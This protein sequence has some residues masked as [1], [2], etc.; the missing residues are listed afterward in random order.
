M[1]ILEVSW[2]N[3]NSYGNVL[4]TI[5][6]ESNGNLYLLTAKNG[7]G[8][9]TIS[10]V[11]TFGIYGK[12]EKKNKSSLPNRINKNLYVNIKLISNN[13]RIEITRGVAPV[14]F[15]VV[16]DGVVYDTSGNTNVQ[17]YLESEI[18]EIPFAVFKNIIVLS[19]NDFKSFLTMSPG[20]KRNIID[21]LFGI[22]VINK[23]KEFVKN[24]RKTLNSDLKTITDEVSFLETNIVNLSE[25]IKTIQETKKIDTAALLQGY[26][27][28]AI[29]LLAN[30]KTLTTDYDKI[31]S[32]YDK[33]VAKNQEQERLLREAEYQTKQ[34][35]S[36]LKL[37]ENA[38]CPLCKSD[39][40]TDEHE[41]YKQKLESD[42]AELLKHIDNYNQAI[43]K[44]SVVLEKISDKKMTLKRDL[45]TINESLSKTKYEIESLTKT[46]I[47]DDIVNLQSVIQDNEKKKATRIKD[48]EKTI[49]DDSFLSIVEDVLGDEGVK[50]LAMNTILPIFNHNITQM[51][52]QIH[53]PYTFK[54][55]DKFECI[56]NSLGEEISPLTLSTGERK[57]ADFIIIIALLKLLK[58]RFP[59]VNLLFLDEIFSSVDTDGVYEIIKILRDVSKECN[60]NTRVINHTELP[61]EL[62]DYKVEIV[63]EG[64]FSK[65]SSVVID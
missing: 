1:R 35:K 26:K 65:I 61:A 17:D 54:F 42:L 62:F 47:G 51:A 57:R 9:T 34:L 14:F 41:S 33:I 53:L 2:R 24:E 64:G 52:Q 25:K 11:I 6:F 59:N 16:I 38:K 7:C 22:T 37:Y 29:S 5:N 48:K 50:N 18:F 39:I 13:K 28:Q 55:N 31:C 27:E 4:Q 58:M 20:D 30:K 44:V 46:K 32:D 23:M 3:F 36:E 56:I 63:K 12:L 45:N 60:I 21:R 43:Y 49:K 19:I 15:N 40:H 8:K 10:E